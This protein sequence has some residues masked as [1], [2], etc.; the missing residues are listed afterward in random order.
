[1]KADLRGRHDLGEIVGYAYRLYG[2]NFAPFFLIALTTVP[3]QVL[4]GVLQDRIGTGDGAQAATAPLQLLNTFVTLIAVG[5]LIFAV[6]E[7]ASGTRPEA[8]RSLDAVFERIR[9]MFGTLLLSAAIVAASAL[10]FPAL[11][12][13]WLVR[14]NATID[15]RRTWWLVLVP[16]AL[17]IYLVI[18]WQLAQQAVMIDG[19][20]NWA[21]LDQSANAVRGNWW[22]VL[23][24]IIVI[25][26]I[27]TGPVLLASGAMLLPPLP[28]ATIF[29][30]VLALVIP[31]PVAAQTL[32]YYDL[33]ARGQP[34]DHPDR[35][36]AAQPDVQGEGP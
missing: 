8:S 27:E 33:K 13:W 16:G 21:A 7:A 28:G 6:D 19:K 3:L 10:A 12:L 36:A 4:M 5:A 31:F 34:D 23:G 18:R 24:V 2:R 14:R 15:G 11:A 29:A 25:A 35:I 22:R 26:L 1:V 32:L 20:R 9:A 30:L 17:T